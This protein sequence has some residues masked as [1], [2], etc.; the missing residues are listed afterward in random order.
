MRISRISAGF[1]L[2]SSSGG[3]LSTVSAGKLAIELAMLLTIDV[4]ATGGCTS[5]GV[6]SGS[7]AIFNAMSVQSSVGTAAVSSVWTLEKEP[8]LPVP[9][10]DA[11]TGAWTS[12]GFTAT[13]K[14]SKMGGMVTVVV[15]LLNEVAGR[16]RIAWKLCAPMSPR[17]SG[18]VAGAGMPS[19]AVGE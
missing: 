4:C 15:R 6:T 7:S 19:F 14:R 11:I 17:A 2:S 1:S 9:A 8:K 12:S 13:S 5:S 16:E 18:S 10:I 3:M